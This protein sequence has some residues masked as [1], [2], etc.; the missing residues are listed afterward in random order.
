MSF[1][2]G[3]SRFRTHSSFAN[4]ESLLDIN[5]EPVVDINPADAEKRGIKTSEMVTVLNDRARTTLKARVSEG[6][7]P[8]LID[9]TQG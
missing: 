8:G 1:I 3:H 6:V 7:Q 9:I 2:Q 5:P 4:V